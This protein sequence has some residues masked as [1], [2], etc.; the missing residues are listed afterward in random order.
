MKRLSAMLVALL[1]FSLPA[2]AAVD[3]NT[4]S[5]AELESIN[6]VG[7]SKAQAIIEYRKKNGPFKSVDELDKVPGFGAK[8]VDAVRKQV[9]V[10]NAK[11]AGGKG[12]TRTNK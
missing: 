11:A 2:W 12:D 10:G 6:G 7:P 3:L 4:A 8:T 5:Q 1:F 9:S